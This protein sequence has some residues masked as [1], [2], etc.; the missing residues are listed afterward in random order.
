MGLIT[1]N[2]EWSEW[3]IWSECPVSC[4]EGTIT[5]D[6]KCTNPKP[7]YGGKECSGDGQEIQLCAT[8]PC[9]GMIY[10]YYYYYYVH[11]Y[12]YIIIVDCL[13]GDWSKWSVCNVSCDGGIQSRNRN[14]TDAMFGGDSCNGL[15]TEYRICNTDECPS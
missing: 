2:G 7:Q 6:R 12:Y 15:A 3:S 10:Y 4:G 14:W 8:N 11:N 13:W 9:P 5:R 1:V